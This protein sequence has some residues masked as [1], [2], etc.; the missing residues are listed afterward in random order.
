DAA[1]NERGP[2]RR[3]TGPP[4]TPERSPAAAA[5]AT[6]TTAATATATAT[7]RAVLRLVDAER[8]P[9]EL[10]AVELADRVGRGLAG[11]H[12]DER[13]AA[14]AAGLAIG[15]HLDVDHL[16]AGGEG[17]AQVLLRGVIG[18]VAHIQSVLHRS[19]RR[20]GRRS[21]ASGPPRQ[22]AAYLIEGRSET[23]CP[24]SE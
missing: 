10:G 12:L 23:R 15:H 9:V 4:I 8:A 3:R 6:T 19:S 22:R 17:G 13:E 20:L 18:E 7:R 1:E 24:T 14:R 11:G 2:I 5:A 21:R 16:A